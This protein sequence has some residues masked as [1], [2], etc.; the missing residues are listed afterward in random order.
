MPRFAASRVLD[1]YPRPGKDH[2]TDSFAYLVPRLRRSPSFLTFSQPSRAGLTPF[3]PMAL[4]CTLL[5]R[6]TDW[7]IAG[8]WHGS[9]ESENQRIRL[10]KEN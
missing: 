8:G 5:A 1:G 9:L 2:V 6:T 10:F 4:C 7:V 3:A